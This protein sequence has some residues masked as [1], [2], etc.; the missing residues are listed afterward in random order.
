[1]NSLFLLFRLLFPVARRLLAL[2]VIIGSTFFGSSTSRRLLM[3]SISFQRSRD[4]VEFRTVFRHRTLLC[5]GSV[6]RPTPPTL[7]TFVL[8]QRCP[9]TIPITRMGGNARVSVIVVS[10]WLMLFTNSAYRRTARSSPIFADDPL[11]AL[12]IYG[13]SRRAMDRNFVDNS[14]DDERPYLDLIP[15]T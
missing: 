9:V 6:S 10:T 8:R 2:C 13:G 15:L 5:V 14:K 4:P 1:M 11:R 12:M 7:P 3:L